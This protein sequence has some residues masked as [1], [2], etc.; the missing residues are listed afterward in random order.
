VTQIGDVERITRSRK[1][2]RCSWC[3]EMI[4]VGQPAVRWL[5][6]QLNPQIPEGGMPRAEYLTRKFGNPKG[7]YARV[8]AVGAGVGIPFAF[9]RITVQPNTIDAHR[10]LTYADREGRQDE[11]AEALFLEY[12]EASGEVLTPELFS[13]ADGTTWACAVSSTSPLPVDPDRKSVV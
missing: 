1:P 13:R 2:K 11:T 10:L 12:Q 7:N 6:F 9:D 4:E 8:T 5:P 3:D